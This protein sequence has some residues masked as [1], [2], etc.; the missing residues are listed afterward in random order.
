MR[1]VLDWLDLHLGPVEVLPATD[2]APAEDAGG[3]P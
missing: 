3:R 2:A 1:E